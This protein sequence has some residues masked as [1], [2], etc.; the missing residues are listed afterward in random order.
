MMSVRAPSTSRVEGL[1]SFMKPP[2]HVLAYLDPSLRLIQVG[3]LLSDQ[4]PLSAKSVGLVTVWI[5]VGVRIC[6]DEC[7]RTFH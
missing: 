5:V 1:P 6:F 7:A 2:N 3:F 4:R